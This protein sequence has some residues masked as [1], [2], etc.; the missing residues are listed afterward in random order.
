MGD[1]VR[2]YAKVGPKFWIGA[3]GKKLKAAG[4][5]AQIVAMYLMTN[6]HANMLGL[7]YLPVSFIAHET[8]LP[9]E[10]ALKGLQSAIEAG[11]CVYDD[12]SEMVWVMEMAAYQIAERL[13]PTDKQAKGVQ[14]EYD[15]L[16]GNPWLEPFFNKYGEAFCMTK[17]RTQKP[18]SPSPLQ[19][20]SK[21][22]R[23]QEQ[24]QEQEQD[25]EQEQGSAPQSDAT[26]LNVETWKSYKT[27]YCQRYGVDPVRNATVNSQIKAFVKRIG[28]D[29]PAVAAH[30]VQSN[31]A[32]Y[33]RGK[34]AT[35][36]MLKDAEGL[37]TEWATGNSVTHTQ[38]M[39]A[40]KTAALGNVFGK[41]IKEAESHE[42][43]AA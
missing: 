28:G 12:E 14:N 25:H 34:H 42:R 38:A 8:G 17:K 13:Q 20:P 30:Y 23:S 6:P 11:F 24:E 10:G 4:M 26:G 15:A 7:F 27:A 5:E 36:L 31:T 37:R 2:D 39:Q 21:A 33:V 18:E 19:A 1:S 29:S 22:H 3:T 40:D 16:P 41:L 32:F 43:I 9:I 35:G